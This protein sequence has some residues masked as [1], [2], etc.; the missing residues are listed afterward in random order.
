MAGTSRRVAGKASRQVW[1][2]IKSW[3]SWGVWA[4]PGTVPPD[5]RGP[6]WVDGGTRAR[7]TAASLRGAQRRSNPEAEGARRRRVPR[8]C[9]DSRAPGSRYA[10]PSDLRKPGLLRCARNDAFVRVFDG[11]RGTPGRKRRTQEALVHEGRKRKQRT[12]RRHRRLSLQTRGCTQALALLRGETADLGVDRKGRRLTPPA[13]E[14]G[15]GFQATRLAN[16]ASSTG[17]TFP[18]DSLSRRMV[19]ITD[20]CMSCISL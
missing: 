14:G 2:P 5:M 10:A 3:G 15:R 8:C 11:A 4:G 13:A 12:A 16:Q 7:S 9:P 18:A 17:E 20:R 1:T 19:R 6:H